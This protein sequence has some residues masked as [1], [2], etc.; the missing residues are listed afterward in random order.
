M[1]YYVPCGVCR[2]CT[3]RA[4]RRLLNQFSEAALII[5]EFLE[6]VPAEEC[7]ECDPD[8]LG[9]YCYFCKHT[10]RGFPIST[11]P[12]VVIEFEVPLAESERERSAANE[13]AS[14]VI[15]G[16]DAGNTQVALAELESEKSAAN[17]EASGGQRM[18]SD[19][20]LWWS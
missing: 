18:K 16:D 8:W 4:W 6:P 10:I 11:T 20:E 7:D 15:V 14:G 2:T 1:D 9:W 19:S 3:Q 5:I 12:G 17:E 13:E